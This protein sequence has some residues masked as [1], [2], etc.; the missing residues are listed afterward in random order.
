[1]SE[2]MKHNETTE[3]AEAAGK[4]SRKKLIPLIAAAVVVLAAIAVG[5]GIYNTPANRISRQ[6]DL[7]NRYLENEQYEEAILAF[8][9]VIAIDDRCVEAY[10]GAIEAYAGKG[11]QE[12]LEAFYDRAL[13]VV[14]ELDEE[15]VAQNMDNVVDIYLAADKVYETDPQKAAQILAEG[16]GKT[17]ENGEIQE[18]LINDYLRAANDATA[19]ASYEEA[20]AIYNKLLE[21]A[22]EDERVRNFQLILKEAEGSEDI[23]AA[24]MTDTEQIQVTV[25]KTE[26]QAD[27][28]F[29]QEGYGCLTIKGV[30]S[31]WDNWD[32][33]ESVIPPQTALIDADGNF[34]FPYKST[35]LTYRISDG[36]VSLTESSPYSASDGYDWGEYLPAYYNLGGGSVFVPEVTTYEMDEDTEEDGV[37]YIRSI[38]WYGGPM[39]DGYCL[40]IEVVE[41]ESHY[42]WNA[43][44]GVE[45]H[46]YIMDKNGAITCTLPE[47]FNEIIA[48]GEGG[49]DTKFSLGWCGEGLFAVFKN[50]YD[51]DWN[52]FSEA[53]GYM[54][55]AGNMILDLSER[56]FTNLFP[57][58]EGL[59]AVRS[60]S[61]MIGFIDKTGALVIPCIY[62]KAITSFSDD[63]I[64]AVKKDGKWGYIGKDGSE[65]IP[66]EYDNA[67]GAGDGLAS[68]VKDG[69]CGLVDYSN[70]VIVPLEYD[71]ISSGEGGTAYAIK[72]GVLYIISK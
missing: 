63:G 26:I 46:S 62:D 61:G 65:V 48:E 12:E 15:S 7:G 34:V 38:S 9:R 45:Y 37:E 35:Y 66:F 51:E 49:F 19:D 64:C 10:A 59:A 28:V 69:K 17:G 29:N 44:R 33:Q 20:L 72:D 1:M 40:V 13:A 39:Q 6:M 71:D 5:I 16:Y 43:G 60:E 4:G 47:D 25:K 41:K 57:F 11:S 58:H 3:T 8:E 32:N 68:V 30:G 52:Y 42:Q 70:R 31:L 23:E 18:H 50:S 36:V 56:G 21:L 54:D 55:P 67:Y 27:S 53:K 14:A 22:A 24:G 2:E